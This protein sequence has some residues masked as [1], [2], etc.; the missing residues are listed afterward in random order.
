[1]IELTEEQRQE[2]TGPQPLR[3]IDPSTQQRYV[4]V[5][6]EVYERL[7]AALDEGALDSGEVGALI[8]RTMREYDT[9]DPLLESYQKYRR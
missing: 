6:E 5:R 3:A 2:L 9:D 8:E 4:L 1:M 7:R